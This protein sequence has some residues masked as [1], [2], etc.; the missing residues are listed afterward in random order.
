MRTILVTP[1]SIETVPQPPCFLCTC[2]CCA[3]A[4]ERSGLSTRGCVGALFSTRGQHACQ[5]PALV[6]AWFSS[7]DGLP[8]GLGGVVEGLVLHGW[9]E[10]KLAV[11]AAVVVPVD[12]LRDGDLQVVDAVP[13]TLVP[14]EFGLEQ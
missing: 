1:T 8:G 11:E 4:C 3:A 12:V 2:S 7:A 10:P 9:D 5:V 6:E 14:H 13:R